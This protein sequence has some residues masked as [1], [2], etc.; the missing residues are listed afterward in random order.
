MSHNEKQRVNCERVVIMERPTNI[1]KE[2]AELNR[3]RKRWV[4]A[5]RENGFEEGIK[6]L[7]ADLYPDTAHFIYELLQNAEDA[8]ATVIRFTLFNDNLKVEHDGSRLFDIKDVNSITSIGTSTK[9]D[10]TTTIGKFGVGFK[11]VFAYTNTPAIH[12][13]YFHFKITDL[14]VPVP[15]E[16]L[17]FEPKTR[18]V[19]PFNRPD[20]KPAKAISEIEKWFLSLGSSS[21]LFLNNIKRIEYDLSD[22]MHSSIT[23][24]ETDDGI[25]KISI[26]DPQSPNAEAPPNG[27]I[28]YW[29][30]YADKTV[31]ENEKG[32]EVELPVSIAYKLER[33]NEKK[34]W[35]IIQS[36][37]Q[38]CIYFPTEK[39]RSDLKFHINAPFASTVARDSIRECDE[40]NQL[41]DAISKLIV[42]SLDD[43]KKRGLLTTDFLE[44]LPNKQDELK[45][46]YEPIRKTIV[47]AFQNNSFVPTKSG[48]YA[49]ARTL[50]RGPASISDVI[51]DDDLSLLTKEKSPLWAKNTMSNSRADKFLESLEIKKWGQKELFYTFHPNEKIKKESIHSKY[52]NLEWEQLLRLQPFLKDEYENK[53]KELEKWIHSKDDSWLMR[54]YALL[55][56]LPDGLKL[57]Y[58]KIVSY[59]EIVSYH[60]RERW[61]D[62]GKVGIVDFSLKIIKC[63]GEQE[64]VFTKSDEAFFFP[65]SKEKGNERDAHDE[66]APLFESSE[67][68]DPSYID[69]NFVKTEVYSS[70]QGSKINEKAKRFLESMGVKPYDEKANI[71]LCL[72]RYSQDKFSVSPETHCSDIKKFL[73]YWRTNPNTD[74]FKDKVAVY[75]CSTDGKGHWC[76]PSKIY[77]DVPYENTGLGELRSIHQK[78]AL[79]DDY[80]ENLSEDHKDFIQFISKLGAFR[81][82]T[83][84]KACIR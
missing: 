46:F 11:S 35:K 10:D 59:S 28:V 65:E 17:S 76:R 70:E 61:I 62:Y 7:L 47:D 83:I 68:S 73:K 67:K 74:I 2:M 72:K 5:N 55:S 24:E 58:S 45:K 41:R 43:I 80:K 15:L 79:W 34:D 42:K 27:R 33:N 52:E 57:T 40:N 18:F 53:I 26:Q 75:G 50:Y 82:L 44:V 9:A 12:S 14:V 63:Y 4:E 19:F 39:E 81:C 23:R 48:E 25:I 6:R 30:R 77:L 38:V 49:S 21:L 22:G 20:K 1:E 78:Y 60:E 29:L 3:K 37:G 16:N 66:S 64:D 36:D 56:E 84:T 13:G 71:E 32:E 51:S 69:V 31:V 8:C 54:L